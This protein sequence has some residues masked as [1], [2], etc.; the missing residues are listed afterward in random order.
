MLT[1]LINSRE[2]KIKKCHNKKNCSNVLWQNKIVQKSNTINCI[3]RI[4]HTL[5]LWQYQVKYR[6]KNQH[7]SEIANFQT[8]IYSRLCDTNYMLLL[9]EILCINLSPSNEVIDKILSCSCG[10]IVLLVAIEKWI[11]KIVYRLNQNR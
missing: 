8:Q 2:L 3:R 6:Q 5:K 4:Q 11:V 10:F 7:R 1:S 9:L